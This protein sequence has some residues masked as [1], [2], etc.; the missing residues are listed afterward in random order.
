MTLDAASVSNAHDA[1]PNGVSG[2]MRLLSEVA[3]G[4]PPKFDHCLRMLGPFGMLQFARGATPHLHFGYCLDDNARA[5]LAAVIALYLDPQSADAQRFGEAALGFVE[6]CRRDDGR[7][8]N[9][10]GPDGTFTDEVGSPDSLGRLVWAA[11][12]AA[13]CAPL[14]D[15]RERAQKLLLGVLDQAESL[16]PLHPMAYSILGLAAAIAPSVAAPI[17]AVDPTWAQADAGKMRGVLERQCTRLVTLLEANA[18]PQWDWFE[19]FMTWGNARMPEAL[20]RGSAA[21]ADPSLQAAGLRTLGFL[22]SVTH[23]KDVFVPVGNKGWYERG[24]ERAIYDQQP[25]EACAMVDVWLAAAKLTGRVEYE[26]KA[27]EAFSWFIGLNTDRLAV[28]E[29]ES[30]GC[31]DGLEPGKLNTNM[32]AESTLSY[33]H[34]HASLAAYFRQ[35]I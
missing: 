31:R 11:G 33:V 25:I 17:P 1:S 15:W 12:I 14:V 8:H 34:A 16:N 26:S 30:G 18:Q 35:K 28:V 13:S 32:G 19:S 7:F 2:A 29:T 27:L 4:N 9:L 21:L 6:S 3:A 23:E 5:F 22:A 20:L 10:K 24:T